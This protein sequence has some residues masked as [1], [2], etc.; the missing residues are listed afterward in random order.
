MRAKAIDWGVAIFYYVVF[1]VAA[2]NLWANSEGGGPSKIGTES[3]TY[4]VTIVKL[5]GEE[6]GLILAG[7]SEDRLPG[8]YT[9]AWAGAH[10]LQKAK[11]RIFPHARGLYYWELTEKN[12]SL[13]ARVCEETRH[14]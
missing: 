9:L 14:R 13:R 2:T 12:E 5:C 1:L 7:P 4:T 8:G 3:T 10:D 6:V 11:D